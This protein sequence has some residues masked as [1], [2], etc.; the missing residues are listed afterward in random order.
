MVNFISMS[1]FTFQVKI[2]LECDFKYEL[3]FLVTEIVSK[4]Y[5]CGNIL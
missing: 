1:V 2:P 5:F 3:C 4:T